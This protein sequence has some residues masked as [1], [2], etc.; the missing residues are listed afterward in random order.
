MYF[1]LIYLFIYPTYLKREFFLSNHLIRDFVEHS[2]A[3]IV[4][5]L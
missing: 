1:L 4:L 3:R 2:L 5:I